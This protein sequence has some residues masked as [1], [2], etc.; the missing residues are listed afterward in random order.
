MDFRLVTVAM[1]LTLLL[2]AFSG[3]S[4]SAALVMLVLTPAMGQTQ[5]PVQQQPFA[6]W[7]DGVRAE[8]LAKGI[9]EETLDNALTG[10]A[11]VPRVLELDTRQPEFT[12]TF[13]GYLD[14]FVTEDRVSRGRALLAQHASLLSRVE[15]QYGVQARFLVAFWGM[16][17]NFGDY[18]GGFPVIASVATLAHDTRRADFFRSELFQALTILDAGHIAPSKMQGS[19]AGAMGQLQFMPSTFTGYAVDGDGDGRKDIWGSL[20]DVFSSAANYL[21]GIGWDDSET[22][23]RE[24]RLPS[25]FDLELIDPKIRKTVNEWQQLG[26]RRANGADL[27]VATVEGYLL[28]PGGIAGPAFLVYK[29]FDA[30]MTWNRSVYYALSVGYLSDRLKGLGPLTTPRPAQDAPLYRNDVLELQQRLNAAGFDAGKPDGMIGSMTRRAVKDYQRANGL[31][32][33]GYPTQDLLTEMRG[34]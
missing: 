17:T 29:N 21:S 31:P 4:L 26:V 32:P 13:W 22:W 18:T 2:R 24:V 7:L 8:A 9:R 14:N 28:L 34:G 6:A 1:S 33:D 20:P 5:E 23:G 11:P 27:P 15:R 25:G 12:R 3:L 30:I 10:L 19:W 16:E